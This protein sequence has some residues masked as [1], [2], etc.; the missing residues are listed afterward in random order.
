MAR[1]LV[2]MDDGR[3]AIPLDEDDVFELGLAI[4]D[5][6]DIRTRFG[7]MEAVK[8]SGLADMASEQLFSLIT[9]RSNP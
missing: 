3:L 1:E 5:S 6:V 4:G 7:V 8:A 2:V 9:R